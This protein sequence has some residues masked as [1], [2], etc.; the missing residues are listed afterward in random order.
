MQ[1][2]LLAVLLMV[3]WPGTGKAQETTGPKAEEAK[4]VIMEI[5]KGKVKAL[6]DI[7]GGANADWAERY[8]A[9]DIVMNGG[10][11]KA[12]HV[13]HLLDPDAAKLRSMS[14]TGHMIRIYDDGR[15]A[16]VTY[17]D[18]NVFSKDSDKAHTTTSK[19]S[20]TVVWTELPD[21]RWQRVVHVSVPEK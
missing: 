12:D 15:L 14:Q 7:N 19:S 9:D 2:V 5:D 17:H 1:K 4:K 6:M 8:D 16:I 13:A 10:G 11:K 20:A 3:F 18:V 21:G